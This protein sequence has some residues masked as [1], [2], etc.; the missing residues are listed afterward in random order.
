MKLNLEIIRDSL[1]NPSDAKFYGVV[2]KARLLDRPL[3]Y[4]PGMAWVP[5][6]LYVAQGD[7][8]PAVPQ[9][10]GF[11]LI[12]TA[13][14]MPKGWLYSG[15]SVL[16]VR[17]TQG[18]VALFHTVQA[19]FDRFQRWEV[20]ILEELAQDSEFDI[21]QVLRLGISVLENPVCMMDSAMRIR[22][23][24]ELTP[25]GEIH[26]H[27]APQALDLPQT[28][29]IK[30]ACHRER[31]IRV[32]YLSAVKVE[33]LRCYCYNLYPLEH[34]AG[35]A[36]ISES[37]R[38]FRESDFALA[39]F[40]FPLFQRAYEKR[41][42]TLLDTE[43]PKVTALVKL[44]EHDP[45][46]PQEQTLLRLAPGEHWRF[47]TL[48]ERDLSHSLPK[49][50]MYAALSALLP[51]TVLACIH[52]GDIVGLVKWEKGEAEAATFRDLLQ[53]MDYF[54]GLSNPF[55]DL[56]ELDNS[57]RQATIASGYCSREKGESLVFF[58]DCLLPYFLG[59]C[60]REMP[61]QALEAEG[62]AALRDYD[63]RKG[64]DYWKTLDTYLKTEMSISRTSQALYIH[65]SSLLK[66]LEKIN[67]LTGFDLENPDTRLYLRLYLR[68][69]EENPES[70]GTSR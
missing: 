52:R 14:G 5:G 30:Q 68:L 34:F 15:A 31:G 47:F 69:Q 53:R 8:L 60:T 46:T 11:T 62:L 35:C 32:P 26:I 38:K 59:Q 23:S 12:C 27:D 9:E 43:S 45:I 63:R 50:Y 20:A 2:P 40:F 33:G 10:R 1:D 29:N 36:W 37:N 61:L 24:S 6:T 16:V 4:T 22:I 57:L 51:G 3:L 41:L 58:R 70:T 64:S 42:R 19:I 7:T 28:V 55:T 39:D 13:E 48:R 67:R 56:G 44:L 17:N 25:T 54:C 49:D 18:A 66:R 65:R 21:C